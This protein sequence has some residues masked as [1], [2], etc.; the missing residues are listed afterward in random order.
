MT[1]PSA[2]GGVPY[3]EDLAPSI[4]FAVAY[5]CLLPLVIYRFLNRKSLTTLL[6][7]TCIFAIGRIVTFALRASQAANESK[8]FSLGLTSFIQSDIALGYIGIASDL[9]NIIRTLLTTPTYGSDT[10]VQSA[11]AG[12][13]YRFWISSAKLNDAE[14]SLKHKKFPGMPPEGTSD[15]PRTRRWIRIGTVSLLY[16]LIVATILGGTA[17]GNFENIV[18]GKYSAQTAM[19]LRFASTGLALG[20][21]LCIIGATIWGYLY[22]PR[23]NKR[24]CVLVYSIGTMMCVIAVYRLTVMGNTTDSLQ[25]TARGSLN[26]R[27]DKAVFYIL[28]ALPEWLSIALLLAFNTRREFNT[29]LVG[30]WRYRDETQQEL[31]KRLKQEEAHRNKLKLR[32]IKLPEQALLR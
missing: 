9:S 21:L 16:A 27:S 26:S 18:E 23:I 31:K 12:S 6:I 22:L 28:H 2:I 19:S 7:G 13:R 17:A 5:G 32:D 30:D 29:G 24:G 10:Y 3:R 8:R 20:L 1:F 11:E 14:E 25:S 4:V 15:H